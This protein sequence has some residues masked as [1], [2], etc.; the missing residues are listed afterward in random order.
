MTRH[1]R[2]KTSHRTSARSKFHCLRNSLSLSSQEPV[3]QGKKANVTLAKKKYGVC[4]NTPHRLFPSPRR[5]QHTTPADRPTDRQLAS[6]P[7]CT[8]QPTSGVDLQQ[9]LMR[10]RYPSF[11]FFFLFCGGARVCMYALKRSRSDLSSPAFKSAP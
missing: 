6:S 2:T 7:T 1:S 10:Q 3:W 11:F 8:F 4:G 9:S 5:S